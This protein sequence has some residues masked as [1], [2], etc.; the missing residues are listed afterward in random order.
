MR[1][2][3]LELESV[4]ASKQDTERI[5]RY[6]RVKNHKEGRKEEER[7]NNTNE[8]TNERKVERR[9]KRKERKKEEEEN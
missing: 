6:Q 1:A 9:S 7:D 4:V 2:R 3:Y 5:C 8:R